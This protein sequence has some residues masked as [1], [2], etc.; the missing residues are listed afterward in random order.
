MFLD[1]DD[2]KYIPELIMTYG[3]QAENV[4]L[5]LAAEVNNSKL[6]YL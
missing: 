2:R 5:K 3:S 6:F 1:P 4:I